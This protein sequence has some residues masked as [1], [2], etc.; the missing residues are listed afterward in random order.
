[1][2]IEDELC[3]LYSLLCSALQSLVRRPE[4]PGAG[5]GKEFLV[6]VASPVEQSDGIETVV[7]L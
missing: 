5:L 3:T 2:D 1:M 4:P 7:I 6:H